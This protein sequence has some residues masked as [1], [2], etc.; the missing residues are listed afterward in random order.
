MWA[1][2]HCRK[3][4][5]QG[6]GWGDHSA[7]PA[8]GPKC[9]AL[10]TNTAFLLIADEGHYRGFGRLGHWFGSQSYG[11]SPAYHDNR[12]RGCPLAI[13]PSAGPIVC[14][15][16][17]QTIAQDEFNHGYTYSGH[18]VAAAGGL[19]KTCASCRKKRLSNVSATWPAPYLAPGMGQ[20]VGSPF[21]GRDGQPVA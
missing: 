16:V 17:A 18:P 12:E 20:L 6:A 21:G 3:N 2:I 9:S 13:S 1:A 11:H 15:E 4:A 8:I 10:W 7:R 19:G 5:V 14:D